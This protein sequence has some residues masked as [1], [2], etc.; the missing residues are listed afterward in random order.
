MTSPE[1]LLEA[2]VIRSPK[3]SLADWLGTGWSQALPQ[4]YRQ[5]IRSRPPC[6]GTFAVPMNGRGRRYGS[7]M[8]L[9]GA[10]LEVVFKFRA[11]YELLMNAG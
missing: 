5:V 10:G 9:L 1:A 7:V 11:R 4:R 2:L 8:G 3:Y 6:E